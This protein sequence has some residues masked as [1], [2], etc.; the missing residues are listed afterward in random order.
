[1]LPF[2]NRLL[3]K[4]E[5]QLLRKK[6]KRTNFPLFQT[7]H[8]V[9]PSASLPQVAIVV[10]NGVS[11]LSTKR[12]RIKRWLVEALR[13][14]LSSFPG[15]LKL[16]FFAKKEIVNKNFWEIKKEIEKT[17]KTIKQ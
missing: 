5:Y 11:S 4:T 9:S 12:H 6:G 7:L 2:V 1:M 15:G 8:F 3:L 14:H 16:V 13:P 10:G 17:T